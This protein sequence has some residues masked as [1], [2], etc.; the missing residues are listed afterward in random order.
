MKGG[1]LLPVLGASIYRPTRDIDLL[2]SGNTTIEHMR[3]VFTE[4]TLMTVESDGLSVSVAGLTVEPIR[5]L[6][7]YGGVQVTVPAKIGTAVT[8]IRVDVGVGDA[9]T[10]GSMEAS[11]PTL[12]DMPAPVLLMYPVETVIAEKFEAIVRFG[13]I[14]SRIKDYFDLWSIAEAHRLSGQ[15][16]AAALAATFTRRGT[17]LPVAPP[18]GLTA[19]FTE[20]PARAV[21][22]RAFTTRTLTTKRMVP[23]FGAVGL[24]LT[25]FLM[26]P[27]A[28][29]ASGEP[30]EQTWTAAGGWRP[31]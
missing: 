8:P 30:F 25:S 5:A 31:A 29:A 1:M 17:A 28:A 26:P 24:A 15:E 13:L 9:I 21:Q 19:T 2:G 12:L 3:A 10:P 20:A 6:D 16:L 22:W 11:Y 7:A 4:V 27:A 18:A 14:N 23:T